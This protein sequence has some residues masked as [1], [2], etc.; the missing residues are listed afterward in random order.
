MI[1]YF[2]KANSRKFGIR[3][4]IYPT[5]FTRFYS[6]RRYD[7]DE[8]FKLINV[9]WFYTF[10]IFAFRMGGIS[11]LTMFDMTGM[12][13]AINSKGITVPKA[14]NTTT[15]NIRGR[16]FL[17]ISIHEDG[18]VRVENG[19]KIN[20]EHLFIYFKNSKSRNP[21]AV[22]FLIVDKNC[23]MIYVNQVIQALRKADLRKVIFFTS[24]SVDISLGYKNGIKRTREGFDVFL[25]Y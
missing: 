11:F 16:F 13:A 21:Q 17:H 2:P 22:A 4:E 10:L 12:Y 24:K 19:A 5:Q 3:K 23:R 25:E 8:I 6:K 18:H 20:P 1:N 9:I 15:R 7:C 14:E